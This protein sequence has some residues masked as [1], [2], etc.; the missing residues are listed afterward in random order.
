MAWKSASFQQSDGSPRADEQAAITIEKHRNAMNFVLE[1][2]K[3]FQEDRR[4]T[5]DKIE[6]PELRKS[7][8]R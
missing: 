1:R 5:I 4:H 3:K 6:D 8:M 2:A 7:A